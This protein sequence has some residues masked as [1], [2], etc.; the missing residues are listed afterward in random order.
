MDGAKKGPAFKPQ[1]LVC[2]LCGQQFGTSSLN[3]HTPQ[4]YAKKMAQWEAGDP[5]TRGK[6]PKHPDEVRAT[7]SPL[8]AKSK[9]DFNDEQ[10][11]EFTSN[12][13]PCPNCGR[14]FLADRLVVHLRSCK[15]GSGSKPVRPPT[16]ETAPQ[17]GGGGGDG[18][19]GDRARTSDPRAVSPTPGRVGAG[20]GAGLRASA[21]TGPPQPTTSSSKPKLPPKLRALQRILFEDCDVNKDGRIDISEL[22]RMVEQVAGD[23][24]E[25]DVQTLMATLDI[26][27]DGFIDRDE[28]AHMATATGESI[29]PFRN[30]G[31]GRKG[32][33]CAGCHAVEYDDKAKFCRDCGRSLIAQATPCKACKE[34]VPAGSRFCP[35][36]GM[37][38]NGAA[39]EERPAGS[40]NTNSLSCK[41]ETCPGC[42]AVVDSE[43]NFCDN[44]GCVIG[45]G[46]ACPKC[47]EVNTDPDAKFC[48]ECGTAMTG[49][50]SAAPKKWE[51]DKLDATQLPE[52]P[53]PRTQKPSKPQGSN[54]QQPSR[55]S[56]PPASSSKE[57]NN[58]DDDYGKPDDR[59]ECQNCGRKFN[60]DAIDRHEQVCGRTRNRKVFDSRKTRLLGTDAAPFI[61][62]VDSAPP[63]VAKKDWK[64]E[65]EDFRRTLREARQVDAVLKAGG[66]AKDLPP[67]TYSENSHYVPCPY[68]GRKFAPDVADRHIPKCST[69]VNK[70]KAPPKRR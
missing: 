35:T 65:S 64:K 69:T 14:K 33:E 1:L 3:I 54:S 28:W 5:S 30:R 38:V 18:S 13:E 49:I 36:C 52:V 19:T 53:S 15:A 50:P 60:Q 58:D 24:C 6:Q 46:A 43:G 41:L 56:A 21:P 63:S 27:Q 34:P 51:D 44:C 11:S 20:A 17:R 70:P 32:R 31:D 62:K 48:D 22:R 29:A 9:Q 16:R 4:C 59:V 67:P 47:G 66:T 40:E 26:N 61:H 57:V 37:A 23:G 7:A 39:G 25:K 8:Q 42:K 45:G 10:F 2:Y 12:L 68:C 55:S